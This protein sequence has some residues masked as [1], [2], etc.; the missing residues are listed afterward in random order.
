MID[1][2]L[3]IPA[4]GPL[5]AIPLLLDVKLE[6]VHQLDEQHADDEVG[7]VLAHALAGPE[8]EAPVVVA[9]LGGA[10]GLEEAGGAVGGGV[11]APEGVAD[12]EGVRVDDEGGAGGDEV[13]VHE[14]RGRGGLGHREGGQGPEAGR[15]EDA[16]GEEGRGREEVGVEAARL[17]RTTAVVGGGGFLPL[18]GDFGAES[19][20]DVTV[21]GEE[22]DVPGDA[23]EGDVEVGVE[24]LVQRLVHLLV[25][26]FALIRGGVQGDDGRVGAGRDGEVV[27][28]FVDGVP[29][30][31][32][33]GEGPVG[34]RGEV[35]GDGEAGKTAADDVSE[36]SFPPRGD[37]A[38]P[39]L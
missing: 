26:D 18:G 31:A 37:G 5:L 22:D 10:A 19:G 21:G 39:A 29:F 8:A 36:E 11:G 7:D 28:H 16:G 27:G 1:P 15:L 17:L 35:F 38:E 9:E 23:A 13:A 24:H 2:R 3:P 20:L 4:P 30:G 14:A 6:P 32:E 25:G 34:F 12:V 33:L